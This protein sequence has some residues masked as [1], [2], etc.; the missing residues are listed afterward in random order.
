[1]YDWDAL[2]DASEEAAV[3]AFEYATAAFEEASADAIEIAL[4]YAAVDFVS[5]YATALLYAPATS[6]VDATDCGVTSPKLVSLMMP[7]TSVI[8]AEPMWTAPLLT[9][10]AVVL[11][12]TLPLAPAMVIE[13]SV[14]VVFPSVTVVELACWAIVQKG[15][16][17]LPVFIPPQFPLYQPNYVGFI[18]TRTILYFHDRQRF[19]ADI[20][21]LVPLAG[22]YMETLVFCNSIQRNGDGS[23]KRRYLADSFFNEPEF[24][25]IVVVL[26][27]YRLSWFQYQTLYLALWGFIICDRIAPDTCFCW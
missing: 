21:Q 1:M 19:L 16:V 20:L 2:F 15:L 3:T 8:V 7:P 14:I 4:L 23:V 9:T 18:T 17:C 22:L 11:I 25:S 27:R 6:V 5:V 24:R 12:D 26:H 13:S 10:T